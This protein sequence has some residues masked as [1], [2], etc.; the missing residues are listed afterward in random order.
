MNDMLSIFARHA[1]FASRPRRAR[2]ALG[3][4]FAA[5]V[6][7]GGVIGEAGNVTSDAGAGPVG[8]TDGGAPDDAATRDALAPRDAG[9]PRDAAIPPPPSGILMGATPYA[10]GTEFRVWAPNA[11]GV[12][13]VG[14]FAA[15]PLPLAPEASGR[16]AAKVPGAHA[17]QRYHYVVTAADGTQLT[18]VDPRARQ[19]QSGESVIVDAAAYPWQTPTFTPVPRAASVLYELHVGTFFTAGQAGQPGTF[20]TLA[21]KLDY[22][23]DLGVTGIELMPSNEFPGGADWGYNPTGYF[24]PKP[25]YGAPDDLRK[26]VD[27]AHAR[28]ISVVLDV[29]YNHYDGGGATPLRCWDGTCNGD[30]G[31]YFFGAGDYASTPWGPRPNFARPEVS[32]FLV[33]DV[34]MWLAEYHVDG[35]RFDSTSNIRA[36][37]GQGSVPGGRDFLRRANDVAHAFSPAA[38][39]VAE[40]L[41]GYAAICQSTAAG[42][43]GF[44]AQ[45]DGFGYDVVASVVGSDDSARNMGAVASAISRRD[46]DDPFRRILFT[47]DH[48]TVGNGS[49]RLPS[50]IDSANPSSWAARKRSML[51]A[52]V[53]LTSPGVPMLFEGQELLEQGSFTSPPPPLDWTKA[54][55]FAPVLAF[56][57]DMIRLRRNLDGA[58]SGLTGKNVEVRTNDTA[59]VVY[60]RRWSKA[61][62]DVIVVANFANKPYARYDIGLPEAGAWHVR[63]DSDAKRYSSDFGGGSTADVVATATPLDGSP[64]RGSVVLAPYGVVVLS[65]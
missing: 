47:E 39:M 44:D 6:A 56:Y 50:R 63:M 45:W 31:I 58:S 26:L 52:A 20:A 23:R 14:P 3:S 65:R 4:L 42:G 19:S 38:L 48:D 43:F 18:R 40:D 13:V 16:F 24:A 2:L 33:D 46:D 7:C 11:K 30:Q 61:G 29:V 9:P 37:D 64:A 36:L 51:A 59:K 53:L 15:A 54:T 35:F 55:T 49:A 34:F 12:S 25:L 28:G 5:L 27:E 41:K 60:T 62:D 10:G 57:R 17:G 1:R 8:S 22:L 32:D 21:Q